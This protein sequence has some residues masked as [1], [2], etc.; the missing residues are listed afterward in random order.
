MHIGDRKGK[1][2]ENALRQR[3][4]EV[5]DKGM[6]VVELGSYCGYS[7]ILMMKELRPGIDTLICI[8]ADAKCIEW[9]RRLMS[10]AGFNLQYGGVKLMQ[11]SAQEAATQV[12]SELN[13]RCIDLLFIDHDKLHYKSDLLIFEGLLKTGSVVVADNVTSFNSPL[14]DYLLHVRESGRYSDSVFHSSTVEYSTVTEDPDD[15]S[16]HDGVEVSFKS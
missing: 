5:G 13:G 15:T 7:S 3:R 1:I 2:L 6:V 11:L 16:L 10:L 4:M 14:N 12:E 9:T 8:D